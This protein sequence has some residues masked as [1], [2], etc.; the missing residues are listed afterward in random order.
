MVT[1]PLEV[2]LLL[3][4]NVVELTMLVIVVPAGM[5]EPVNGIPTDSPAVEGV[6]FV[7]ILDPRTHCPVKVITAGPVHCDSAG[8][9]VKSTMSTARE[10]MSKVDAPVMT[11]ERQ[12]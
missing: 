6:T 1:V 10:R 3:I 5:P 2:A 9:A 7:M 8:R 12:E 4:V 11:L